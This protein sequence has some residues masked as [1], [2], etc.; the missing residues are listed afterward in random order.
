MEARHCTQLRTS[1]LCKT[2][3][4]IRNSTEPKGSHD[5]QF[6]G[7]NPKSNKER[8]DKRQIGNNWRL[9]EAQSRHLIDTACLGVN[10]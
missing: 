3:L 5:F 2:N 6:H 10:V 1:G 4:A 8:Q 9:L 7:F